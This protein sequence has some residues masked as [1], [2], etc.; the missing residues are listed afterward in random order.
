VPP[1]RTP[2]DHQL[3][4]RRDVGDRIRRLRQHRGLSQERLA[5]LAGVDRRTIG[6]WELAQ[7]PPTLDDLTALARALDVPILRLFWE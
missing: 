2:D 5:E 7:A 4:Q 6:R 1:T 3:Q